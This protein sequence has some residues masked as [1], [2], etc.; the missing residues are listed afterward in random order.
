M[1]FFIIIEF[2]SILVAKCIYGKRHIRRKEHRHILFRI[3]LVYLVSMV[4]DYFYLPIVPGLFVEGK[5]GSCLF[6]DGIPTSRVLALRID[7]TD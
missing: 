4:K 1:N 7:F 3:H 2:S 6:K 5:R